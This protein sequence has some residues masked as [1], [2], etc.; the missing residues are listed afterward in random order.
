MLLT[1]LRIGYRLLLG[2]GIR[3]G[4]ALALEQRSFGL[5]FATSDQREG[6]SAFLAKRPAQ[7]KGQ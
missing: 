1:L 4:S 6:M 3:I 2:T 7:F 5:L